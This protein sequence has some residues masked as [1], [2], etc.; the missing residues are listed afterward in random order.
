VTENVTLRV[1]GFDGE[2]YT[3]NATFSTSYN[4]GSAFTGSGSSS[5]V[6][7]T[8]YVK[9]PDNVTLVGQE[10]SS[11]Q[12][13]MPAFRYDEARAGDIWQIVVGNVSISNSTLGGYAGNFTESF[14]KVQNLTVPAGTFRVFSMDFSGDNLSVIFPPPFYGFFAGNYSLSGRECL[15]YGTNRLISMEMHST[16]S[17]LFFQQNYTTSTDTYQQIELMNYTVP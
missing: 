7:R 6:N 9:V 13:F 2:Y 1:V 17:T 3:I 10:V 5:V 15:E 16:L 8:G 11:L 12:G 4:E 14:G